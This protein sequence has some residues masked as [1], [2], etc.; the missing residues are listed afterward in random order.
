VD[1]E[2]L[3][4][5]TLGLVIVAMVLVV[6]TL[7]TTIVLV[8]RVESSNAAAITAAT[9]SARD[10]M[11]SMV[12]ASEERL[13]AE[14][15]SSEQRTATAINS[16]TLY[17]LD[18]E[19]KNT[20]LLTLDRDRA[21]QGSVN[22]TENRYFRVLVPENAKDLKLTLTTLTGDADLFLAHN[23]LPKPDTEPDCK[24]THSGLDVDECTVATPKAGEYL[25]RVLGYSEFADFRIE[26]AYTAA[27]QSKSS[28]TE[29]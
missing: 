7:I 25:I 16:A 5:V 2:Q 27:P 4:K 24:S 6:A 15:Q 12:G 19:L 26:A 23:R 11:T 22:H 17:L 18:P 14:I 9:N 28:H 29:R 10:Q 20:G 3:Q 13:R 1:A 21:V 8:R